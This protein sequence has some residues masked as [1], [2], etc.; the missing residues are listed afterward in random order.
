MI[1]PLASVG[2]QMSTSKILVAFGACLFSTVGLA[3]TGMELAP[4]AA[5][6]GLMHPLT[7]I[8]HWLTLLLVGG[9]IAVFYTQKNQALKLGLATTLG[10]SVLL[11]WS[12]LHYTGDNFAAY[13][14]AY[15]FTSTLLIVAGS[16]VVSVGRH[17][18]VALT[19][20]K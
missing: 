14:V 1:I 8:D 20:D 10:L 17:L 12:F 15:A 11:I 5:L 16:Q 3:H 6:E 9:A 2:N 18:K 19:I 13:A 7:G 4:G